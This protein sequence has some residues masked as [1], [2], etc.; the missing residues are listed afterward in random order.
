[1]LLRR[2]QIE[3]YSAYAA[4]AKETKPADAEGEKSK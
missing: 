2:R 1:M 4:M 3:T